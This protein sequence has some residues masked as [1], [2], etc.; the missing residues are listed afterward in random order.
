MATRLSIWASAAATHRWRAHWYR[1]IVV[2]PW[3][4]TMIPAIAMPSNAVL[5]IN[6]AIRNPRRFIPFVLMSNPICVYG[7]TLSAIVLM[8]ATAGEYTA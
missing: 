5:T 3:M 7:Y 4:T 8:T 2:A 1:L 6:S